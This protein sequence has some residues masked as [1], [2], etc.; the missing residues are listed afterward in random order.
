M[1]RSTLEVECTDGGEWAFFLRSGITR[2][3]WEGMSERV[4][5]VHDA[6]GEWM[7]LGGHLTAELTGWHGAIGI[8]RHQQLSNGLGMHTGAFMRC[9][10]LTSLLGETMEGNSGSTNWYGVVQTFPLEHEIR[11]L[12]MGAGI[13][14]GL[15]W[16]LS[17]HVFFQGFIGP[18]FQLVHHTALSAEGEITH[19][20]DGAI[21]RLHH[22]YEAPWELVNHYAAQTG[23]WIRSGLTVGYEF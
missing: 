15:T 22:G 16:D 10:Q 3:D 19:V 5:A 21:E 23:P 7:D 1:H 2:L 9:I 8:R 17:E 13:E 12:S 4:A 6:Q 20:V 18:M 14:W 11:S